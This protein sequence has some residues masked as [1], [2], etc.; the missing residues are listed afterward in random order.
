MTIAQIPSAFELIADYIYGRWDR[1][2]AVYQRQSF[3]TGECCQLK[4]VDVLHAVLPAVVIDSGVDDATLQRLNHRRRLKLVSCQSDLIRA[5]SFLSSSNTFCFSR[6]VSVFLSSLSDLII[7]L[8]PE[9]SGL[10]SFLDFSSS[11]LLSKANAL[12]LYK[13]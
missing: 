2:H 13:K 7:D 6:S 4:L 12:T 9:F 3:A 10:A 8:W 11:S 1:I 5:M